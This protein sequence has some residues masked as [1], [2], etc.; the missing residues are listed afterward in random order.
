[1]SATNVGPHEWMVNQDVICVKPDGS[2]H[3]V[4]LRVGCPY[5]T[6]SGQW[7][8]PVDTGGLY[9]H[10]PDIVGVDS[11]QALCLALSLIRK[12]LEH[13][14]DA[15]GTILDTDNRSKCDMSGLAA[16]FGGIGA[17]GEK[18]A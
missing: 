6:A 4:R 2:E 8:C 3:L 10:L 17:P 16:T 13:F 7:A 11:L 14:L 15:G 9:N 12:L 1:M 18:S 5:Q